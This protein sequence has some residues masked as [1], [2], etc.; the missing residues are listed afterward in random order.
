MRATQSGML[1]GIGEVERDTGISKDTLRI[2]ERRYGFP[3][4]VR[5]TKGERLYDAGELEQ[6]RLIRRL[7]DSGKRPGKIV[8]RPMSELQ[9]LGAGHLQV[10]ME[11]RSASH[12]NILDT[13]K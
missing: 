8:G 11:V 10:R 2:W 6:L 4:P 1:L 5:D 3:N 13:L 9:Q 12:E 7:L